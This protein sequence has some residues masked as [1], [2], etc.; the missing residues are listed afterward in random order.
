[1]F[2]V[3]YNKCRDITSVPLYSIV[4]PLF[5]PLGSSSHNPLYALREKRFGLRG[6]A[7]MHLILQLLARLFLHV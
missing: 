3:Y 1:M 7:H 6:N 2:K 5:D 4:P